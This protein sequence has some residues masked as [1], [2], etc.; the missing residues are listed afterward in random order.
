MQSCSGTAGRGSLPC[1]SSVFLFS[2]SLS[3]PPFFLFFLSLPSP[4]PPPPGTTHKSRQARII[5]TPSRLKTQEPLHPKPLPRTY[6]Q[7]DQQNIL[8]GAIPLLSS[9][10]GNNTVAG[11]M[12]VFNLALN[13]FN[14]ASEQLNKHTPQE[15]FTYQQQ[16]QYRQTTFNQKQG[17]DHQDHQF[18]STIMSTLA[19]VFG[20]INSTF[21]SLTHSETPLT[22]YILVALLSYIVFRI[23]YGFVSWIVR[24]VINLVKMSIIITVVTSLLWFVINI[25]SPPQDCNTSDGSTC[26][27]AG[28]GGQNRA[29]DPISKGFSYLQTRFQAEYNRQQQYLQNQHP[30]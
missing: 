20:T 2:L 17:Q 29:Q 10:L 1:L 21:A 6:N 4:Y 7:M 24:S 13:T 8:Q 22:T 28:A 30:Y 14:T 25:T 12:A 15:K 16:Q 3:F 11:V 26:F 23:V 18:A 19:M 9:V 27:N 5:I